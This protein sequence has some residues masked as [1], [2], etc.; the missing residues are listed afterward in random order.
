MVK[1][2]MLRVVP[3]KVR[4][5]QATG[6]PPSHMTFYLLIGF[7]EG[8][9]ES[10]ARFEMLNGLGCNAYAM[11]FRDLNGRQGVDGKGHPQGK[12]CKPL[13]DWINGHGF[14]TVP[15]AEFDRY[16]RKENQLT[17]NDVSEPAD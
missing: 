4:M 13:R 10:M 8:L 6:I 17:F 12:W 15:F 1:Y 5:L 7:D 16:V 3:E 9:D 2:N 14:R 11:L